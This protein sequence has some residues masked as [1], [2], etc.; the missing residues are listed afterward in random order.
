MGGLLLELV[1]GVRLGIP[2][3]SWL[4]TMGTS[5]STTLVGSIQGWSV[6]SGVKAVS[7]EFV[8]KPGTPLFQ[9]EEMPSELLI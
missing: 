9:V 4:S 7:K 8:S 2:L 1:S 5:Q 6:P 3:L